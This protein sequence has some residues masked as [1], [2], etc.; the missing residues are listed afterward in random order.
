MGGINVN[1]N[2]PIVF[3]VPRSGST[4]MFNIMDRLFEDVGGV[5]SQIHYFVKKN[6][7]TVN[8]ELAVN[9]YLS[10]IKLS[11]KK[12]IATYRDFRNVIISYHKLYDTRIQ[13]ITVS[14]LFISRIKQSLECL[15]ILKENIP[16]NEILFLRY[17]NFFNNF[18]YI[19]D[20]LEDF[21]DYKFS[22]EKKRWIAKRF[23]IK[24]GNKNLTKLLKGA[25]KSN[26]GHIT[27]EGKTNWQTSSMKYMDGEIEKH[28]K[29]WGYKI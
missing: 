10:T 28:L 23:D 27:A 11:N 20:K 3:G 26:H 18:D 4:L 22:S 5:D 29:L 12:I 15:R 9:E 21:Y 8:Y 19:F 14:S 7:A 25:S 13:P 16:E 17:E 24:N 1:H 6:M 2:P